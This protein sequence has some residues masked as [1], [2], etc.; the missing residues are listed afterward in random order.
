MARNAI[1]VGIRLGE[2]VW[3]RSF[4]D[5]CHALLPAGA[6]SASSAARPRSISAKETSLMPSATSPTSKSP[7]RRSLYHDN[8]LMRISY[9]TND[10]DGL[11]VI[12]SVLLRHL[13]LRKIAE[14]QAS[15]HPPRQGCDC[16]IRPAVGDSPKMNLAE[17]RAYID[18]L[19]PISPRLDRS[20]TH[21]VGTWQPIATRPAITGG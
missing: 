18:K 5:E 1:Q 4:L 14:H 10:R 20:Q 8:L 12:T 13:Y 2:L 15:C 6:R 3:V 17:V 9:E 19:Q 16:P 21:G 11:E 7:P